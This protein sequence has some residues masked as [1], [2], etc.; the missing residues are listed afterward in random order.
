MTPSA[1]TAHTEA[2]SSV[3][4]SSENNLQKGRER[5]STSKT[6]RKIGFS[7][8]RDDAGDSSDGDDDTLKR[9][10]SEAFDFIWSKIESSIKDVLRKINKNVFD[11]LH[12]WVSESFKTIRS[13]GRP[14]YVQ[15]TR[16]YP[17]VTDASLKQLYTALVCTKN[18][19]FV[20][21]L[22][23]F[24]ELGHHLRSYGSHVA[25]LSSSDFSASNGIGGCLKSLLRQFLTVAPDVADLSILSL[26]YNEQRDDQPVV[27]IIED[28]ERCCGKI[29]SDFILM[30][31]DWV[32][33]VPVI[34]I[35]GV[36]T[37]INAPKAVLPSD[38]LQMLRPFKF[39]LGSPAERMDAVVEAILVRP[40]SW[41]SIGHKVALFLKNNFL[42]QDGT[43]TAFI[44]ALKIACVLHFS[45]EPLSFLLKE[46]A[47][48][49]VTEACIENLFGAQK[50]MLNNAF[51]LPS[52][53]RDRKTE[54]T[55]ESLAHGL[56]AINS[57]QRSW[58]AVLLCLVR[59]GKSHKIQLLDLFCEALDPDSPTSRSLSSNFNSKRETA[60]SPFSEGH[61]LGRSDNNPS[62]SFNQ[63]V[64]RIRGL[65]PALMQGLLKDW[66]KYVE[67]VPE[68]HEK[69]KDLC[70]MLKPGEGSNL[71]HNVKDISTRN[72]FQNTPDMMD[73]KETKALSQKA[74]RLVEWMLRFMTPIECL[75]FHEICC[76]KDVDKLQL[77]L[78]G[79][80][81]RRIQSDLME[82]SKLILCSCCN[83]SSMFM[84]S[85]HDTSIMY[86]LAQEHG[87]VINLHDWYQSFKEVSSHNVSTKRKKS[88]CSPSPKKRKQNPASSPNQCEAV[89]QARFC[90]AVMELQITGL[91]RMPSKRRPDHVQRAA[92]GL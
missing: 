45:V 36:A 14:G 68:I 17:I 11:E 42:N 33:K 89:T 41:F 79:D 85:L 67:D 7:F 9:L 19:E 21:D 16:P 92:F 84:P 56:K 20:D 51:D 27:I 13:S 66:E 70:L 69:V 80:P 10:K 4:G 22:L 59:A 44:R 60:L 15:A 34:L 3:H 29:L 35:M 78:L 64:S 81:R 86:L 40:C 91:F 5:R 72:R 25:N 76:F 2:P 55:V 50:S 52:S 54:Q 47:T 53:R 62:G 49:D 77:A 58:T 74:S 87:D 90:R 18:M 39:V 31:S 8:T 63:V 30:L 83:W 23:T 71:R 43:L 82:S 57:S 61:T 38:A 1:A 75:P 46:L 73:A 37:T 26:W 65:H 32:I 88:K 28:M 48:D 6:R 24:E 12:H